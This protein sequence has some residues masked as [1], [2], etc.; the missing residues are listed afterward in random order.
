MVDPK[1][2]S[3]LANVYTAS[4]L[5]DADIRFGVDDSTNALSAQLSL[6]ELKKTGV[7]VVNVK[8]YG[9]TGDGVADDTAE[10]QAA[11]D[12]A[13]AGAVGVVFIPAGLYKLSAT[14]NIPNGVHIKGGGTYATF[15]QLD[16]TDFYAFTSSG[17]AAWS[18]SDLTI[19]TP[20]GIDRNGKGLKLSTGGNNASCLVERVRFHLLLNAV[21]TTH[22]VTHVEF[23]H[24]EFAYCTDPAFYVNT[25]SVVNNLVF[26]AC[27]FEETYD[28][29]FEQVS[30][31]TGSSLRFDKCV[32]ESSRGQYAI[33]LGAHPYDV[34]FLASHFENNGHG[35]SVSNT[36]DVRVI[37]GSGSVNFI[38]CNFSTPSTGTSGHYNILGT[39]SPA[40][41]L[42]LIGNTF[43]SANAGN[44]ADYTGVAYWIRNSKVVAIGNEYT[45][46]SFNYYPDVS[47]RVT[48][49]A[50][51]PHTTESEVKSDWVKIVS[52]T[53]ATATTIA[54]IDY[55]SLGA[56]KNAY[57][58]MA[59]VVGVSEDATV[60]GSY[61]RSCLA[62]R[63]NTAGTLTLIGTVGDSEQESE[64][65][66]DCAWSVS[67]DSEGT[68]LLKVTGKAA[69]NM[70]WTAR[71]SYVKTSN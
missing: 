25:G 16:G 27:R 48:H 10:I 19:W 41:S 57:L 29:H 56:D 49:I 69:T 44:A 64:A 68:I 52:T 33:D 42:T 71:I 6:A 22:Y 59:E 58:M 62:I 5:V 13:D 9:A 37:N 3:E 67:A 30:T 4:D 46:S 50:E 12:A 23:R 61:K 60:Y 65:G 35:G 47:T 24:C 15:I 28:A 14:V 54:S 36:A 2:A 26:T 53:N 51:K 1:K 31:V 40:A 45:Y 7:Q 70:N 66:L 38:S 20:A 21:Q 11:I 32:I 63:N 8:Q 17:T 39:S 55:S 43:A 34:V 18:I